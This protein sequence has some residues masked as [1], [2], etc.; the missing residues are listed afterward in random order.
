MIIQMKTTGLDEALRIPEPV[1]E[2][3]MKQAV[4]N[5]T[6]I[7]SA[8]EPKPNNARAPKRF[9]LKTWAKDRWAKTRY[10]FSFIWRFFGGLLIGAHL[11]VLALKVFPVP[12]TLLM[13]QRHFSGQEITRHW[14]P[15]EN[16]SPYVVQAVLA[17]EDG[18]FCDHKGLDFT[19]IKAAYAD[20]QKKSKKRGGSTITQQSAKNVF[21]WNGGGMVRK[22]GEAWFALLIDFIWGKPRTMEIYLNVAE[23]GDGYFGIEAAAQ[24]RFG[25]LAKD[26]TQNQAALLAA[27]LPNPNKWRVT[28]PTPFI[29][30]RAETLQMRMAVI[31]ESGYAACLP[32]QTKRLRN[33]SSKGR[34]K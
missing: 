30:G 32:D 21:F 25:V 19:A 11:Y 24:K 28:N 3:S 29:S 9:C 15:I 12:G 13:V 23:W 20:N 4:E 26:L 7:L 1:T 8:Q 2:R 5:N 27:V 16:I 17:G 18:R 34:T 14:T 31:R 10:V 33:K 22:A 6:D